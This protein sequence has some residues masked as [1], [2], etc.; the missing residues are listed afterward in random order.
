MKR[1]NELLLMF[2]RIMLKLWPLS[3]YPLEP[4]TTILLK[5]AMISGVSLKIVWK[6][7]IKEMGYDVRNADIQW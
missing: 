4:L 7:E 6:V 1:E 5:S 3:P 2:S